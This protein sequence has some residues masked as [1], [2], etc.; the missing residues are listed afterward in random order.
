MPIFL[1]DN[2]HTPL[3]PKA[4]EALVSFN[5]ST[6][7]HGHPMSTSLPGRLAK[8]E[9]ELARQSISKNIGAKPDQIIF[10]STGTQACEWGLEILKAQNFTTV[11]SSTIEHKSVAEKSTNLF[12]N[13]DLI[14]NKHGTVSFPLPAP[15][16][17]FVCIHVQNEL[18]S[19]Q[20]IE[21][22]SV[23]FFSDITQ[24]IGKLPFSVS[25]LP[26]LKIAA[27]SAHKFGGPVLG[28]LY[29]Q[30]PSWWLPLG[31]GGQYHH[32]RPGTPDV[33]T[34]IAA[35]VALEETMKT[36]P[37]RFENALRFRDIVEAALRTQGIEIIGDQSSRIPHTS[38]INIGKKMGP[39]IMSQL[40]G[41]GVYVGL[42]SAC[43]SLISSANPI[44]SALG[45]GGHA[46]DYIRVSQFGNYG[47]SE[48][49]FVAKTLAKYLPK[50]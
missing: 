11:Y 29:L 18:G 19:I 12:G 34:I 50:T 16:S 2:A 17:A 47:E 49:K 8:S 35:A 39:Y 9:L 48:A 33:G 13:N 22:I 7:G 23:P 25:K 36:L 3:H 46:H 30:N 42:G 45:R 40:E 5:K 31:P 43:S 44:I 10:A 15:N 26:N 37:T 24:S 38:F 32:D 20:P 14:P 27:F 1:D 6:A 4:I 41:D 21:K 28:I